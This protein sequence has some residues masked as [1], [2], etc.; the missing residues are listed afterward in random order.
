[1]RS[2]KK[3][4][5]CLLLCLVL[6][7]SLFPAAALAED[8]DE[9]TGTIALVEDPEE[10]A[11]EGAIAPASD[12]EALSPAGDGTQA[13]SG[14]C[15]ENLTW[16]L[17]DGVLTISGTGP[18][19]S[20]GVYSNNPPWSDARRSITAVVIGS[21]V[22]TIGSAAF[23]KCISLTSVSIPETVTS[24]EDWTFYGCSSLTN[25]LIPAGVTTIGDYAFYDCSSLTS[26]TIM[27]G[28][29]GIGFRAF[30]GCTALTSVTVDENN[31][32]FSSSDGVL[33]SK[34][35]TELLRYPAGKTA[36]MYTIPTGVTY[37]GDY[38]FG[39][40]SFLTNVVIPESVTY[41]D[42]SAF[43]SCSSLTSIVI[44]ESVTSIGEQAFSY[45]SSL[46]S[47]TLPAGL[48]AIGNWAFSDCA[49]LTSITIPE[50]VTVVGYGAFFDCVALASITFEGDAP[51]F[52]DET[53]GS[54][55]FPKRELTAYYPVD[56][57]GW[58]EEVLQNYGNGTVTWVPYVKGGLIDSGTFGEGLTWRLTETGVLFITGA[59]AMPDYDGLGTF[60]P[61]NRYKASILRAMIG[62]GVTTIGD[63]AFYKCEAMESVAIGEGVTD[64]GD[65]AFYYCSALTDITIPE[66]VT[67]IDESAFFGC[68]ALE[69]VT[70]P[71]SVTTIGKYAF[72]G[73][74]AL[75][76]VT[77][78]KGEIGSMAFN[79]C[80]ALETVTI[81]AGVTRIGIY[82]FRDCTALKTILFLGNA[83][84]IGGQAFR[85]VTATAFYPAGDD[86][87]TEDVRQPYAGTITWV[88]GGKC[89][90]NVYWSLADGT[91]TIWG[92]GGMYGYNGNEQQPW[93]GVIPTIKSVV[94]QTGVTGIGQR[95]FES[96]SKLKNV[97]IPE[98]VRSIGMS[99]FSHCLALE[100]IT[101]PGGVRTISYGAFRYSGLNEITFEG[102]APVFSYDVFDHVTATA[103]YPSDNTTWTEDKK[104]D[105]YGNITWVGVEL[106]LDEGVCGDELTWKVTRGG[107][108]IIFGTGDMTDY[109]DASSAPW[110]SY[111]D[112]IKAVNIRSGVTS[113][114]D[115][116]FGCLTG[117]S[118]VTIPAS[119]TSIGAGAFSGCTGLSELVLQGDAPSI[120]PDA[121]SGLT[122]T[123]YYSGG[124]GW[125]ET[126]GQG[127]GG[128]VE[129]ICGGAFAD[130]LFWRFADGVLTVGGAGA[131]P[132]YSSS[133]DVPWWKNVSA[134]REAV[135]ESG[136]T[137]VG[138]WSF[139]F[140]T[141]LRKIVFQGSAP[142]F[143]S[144]AFYHV[145][146][147]A[148][149]PVEDDTWTEEVRQDYGGKITWSVD[150][151][152]APNVFGDVPAG[153]YY[154]LPVLWAYYHDPQITGGISENEFGPGKTCT[155]EQIVTFLWKACGAPEPMTTENPF[156]DVNPAKYY[157]KAVMWAVEKGITGGVGDGKFGVGQPCTREQAMTFLWKAC[158]SPEPESNNN[159]FVDVPE[160]KWYY[161]PILWAVENGITGG[162]DAKHFGVGQPC[163]RGQ[164]VTF[165]YKALAP[166]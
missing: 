141:S 45:C 47:V 126:I 120:A 83:P 58:T 128:T 138:N 154:Y 86:T 150:Y 146:A 50:G 13:S 62:S 1:M 115:H 166:W 106:S 113:L 91:L 164:I 35:K 27:E 24:I 100:T 153:K 131:I 94:I 57:P 105:Y 142:D 46:E 34:D 4:L 32:A 7:L 56:Y 135:I 77:V 158:D 102:D 5:L 26:V 3:R 151:A 127:Y 51:F 112:F 36:A 40:C 14:S 28:V 157:Y 20:F 139:V 71:E 80:T 90:K 33:F 133:I 92:S 37:I 12:P 44:P 75:T 25:I 117:V 165:L 66:G 78:P 17:E 87:W 10:P 67:I 39:G 155:R 23:Y 144:Q 130:G 53:W 85:S 140:C 136:V 162:V 147:T 9:N 2:T 125:S 123:A 116:A 8:A 134:I 63:N 64:I 68:T 43:E 104:Q 22:T 107:V 156:T 97:S 98:S 149:Y 73:C 65:S 54:A 72:S 79:G 114:G 101:L 60:A 82:A 163:T 132:D 42:F 18:M 21:G 148:F 41:I 11:G 143:G 137:R 93:Y 81:R 110:A 95:A 52:G 161:K 145:T 89:G 38:A 30:N 160:G 111:G 74:V 109:P 122:L 31:P 59:G 152:N 49:A 88:C 103:Y 129:W 159:P 29:T 19:T 84:T 121:F 119:V 16:T 15:G 99:A 48:T 96:C 108:L 55:V 124:S 118:S 76:D 6:C 69:S 61:W 70:I